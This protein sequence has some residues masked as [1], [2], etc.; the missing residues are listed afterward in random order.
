MINEVKLDLFIFVSLYCICKARWTPPFAHGPSSSNDFFV[1][2]RVVKA[3]I[4]N[5]SQDAA[6]RTPN[7]PRSSMCVVQ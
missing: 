5:Y 4:V 2:Q 6:A 3:D 7:P 1:F